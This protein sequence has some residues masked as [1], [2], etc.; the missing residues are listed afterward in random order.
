MVEKLARR[1][2]VDKARVQIRKL[3]N[4]VTASLA[5]LRGIRFGDED[6]F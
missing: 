1:A 3:C 5:P 2:A 4:T 6:R